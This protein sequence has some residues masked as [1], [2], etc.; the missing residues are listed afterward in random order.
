MTTLL[1]VNTLRTDYQSVVHFFTV[2]LMG[3]MMPCF[4]HNNLLLL[5]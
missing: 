1:P 3:I 4:K 2:S 5:R